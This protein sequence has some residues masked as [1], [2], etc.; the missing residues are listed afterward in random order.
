MPSIV[1]FDKSKIDEDDAIEDFVDNEFPKYDPPTI[2]DCVFSVM[3]LPKNEDIEFEQGYWVEVLG[4]D[5]VWHLGL[6]KRVV[7]QAPDD[8]DYDDPENDGKPIPYNYF[9]NVGAQ[10][11]VPAKYVR[12]PETGLKKVFGL[13]PWLWQQYALLKIEKYLRFDADHER[14]YAECD[15]IRFADKLWN[16]FLEDPKNADFK[17]FYDKF[18]DGP[19]DKLVSHLLSPFLL[20]DEIVE[21]EEDWDLHDSDISVYTYLSVIGSGWIIVLIVMFV[22]LIVPIILLYASVSSS[23]RFFI[24]QPY[25][26]NILTDWETFCVPTG[27]LGGKIMNVAVLAVYIIRVVPDSFYSFFN[28]AGSNDT[29]YSRLNSLR[30]IVWD[31]GDDTVGQMVGYKAQ[32]YMNTA[33][34]VVLYSIML[35]ILFNTNDVIE[36][37][38]NA[39]AIEFIHQ[40]DEEISLADWF[41]AGDRWI[42]GGAIELTIRANIR[43]DYLSTPSKLCKYYGI[44]KEK[45]KEALGTNVTGQSHSLKNYKLAMKDEQNPEFMNFEDKLWLKCEQYALKSN[46]TGA[47]KQY[48]KYQVEFGS[49]VGVLNKLH[50]TDTAFFRRYPAYRTWSRWEKVLYLPKLSSFNIE[51]YRKNHAAISDVQFGIDV[52]DNKDETAIAPLADGTGNASFLNTKSIV[53]VSKR[54]TSIEGINNYHPERIDTHDLYDFFLDLFAVF[55]LASLVSSVITAVEQRTYASVPFRIIDGILE[56]VAYLLQILF[57]VFLI[58]LFFLLFACY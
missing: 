14:D 32:L 51:E 38:L 40:I 30:K 27:S 58:G 23:E 28:T 8:Y 56:V 10:K 36:I 25:P 26:Y 49:I 12:A 35:F 1:K 7:A 16:E 57:P 19:Q 13:R 22:Q 3:T 39:L 54:G 15:C 47:L 18:D 45:L 43:L 33:Y 53:P 2:E 20:M 41:D 29:P 24:D 17:E 21:N 37:I 34:I 11:L 5:M 4:N 42:T 55:T 50:I 48:K 44:D 6:C 31:Q 9:F 46:N 52:S